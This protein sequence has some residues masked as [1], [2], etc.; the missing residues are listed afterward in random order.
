L[1]SQADQRRRS[2]HLTDA[3]ELLRQALVTSDDALVRANALHKLAIVH[4][5]RAQYEAAE[6][7]ARRAVDLLEQIE[8]PGLLGNQLMFL[9]TLLVGDARDGEALE[10]VERA[11]PLYEQVLGPDH[12]EVAFVLSV[13]VRLCRSC[14]RTASARY[15]ERRRLSIAG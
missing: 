10:V 2:G 3:E 8:E 14:N 6:R 15:Y 12:L 5:R 9:A 4:R 1:V 11:L 7:C 13:A